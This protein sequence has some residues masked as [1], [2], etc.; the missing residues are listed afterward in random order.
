MERLSSLI[1][2][3]LSSVSGSREFISREIVAQWALIAGP[4]SSDKTGH[5]LALA[6]MLRGAG[7]HVG[8]FV[9]FKRVDEALKKNYVLL[10]LGSGEQVTLAEEAVHANG[11]DG[12]TFC[13]LRF[14]DSAFD[15]ARLWLE[16]DMKTAQ[17]FFIGDISKVEVS[18]RGHYQATKNA[19]SL[20]EDRLTVICVRADQLF[21]VVE[22][23]DLDDDAVAILELPADSETCER[24]YRKVLSEVT[25]DKVSTSAV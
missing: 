13:A 18:G 23:F 4:K 16:Q 14:D 1:A 10:G 19:L 24:F 6:D 25:R 8:G 15:L 12:V 7:V 3:A 11:D 21:Y 9:Q 5:A 2:E 17:V 20:P 22:K